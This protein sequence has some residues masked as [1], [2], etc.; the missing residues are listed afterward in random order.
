MLL[1]RYA[2]I[3]DIVRPDAQSKGRSDPVDTSGSRLGLAQADTIRK[4]FVHLEGWRKT[5]LVSEHKRFRQTLLDLYLTIYATA[6]L[7]CTDH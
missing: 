3:F 1:R 4:A 2:Q 5:I 6:T 7:R